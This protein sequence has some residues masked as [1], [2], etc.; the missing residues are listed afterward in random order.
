MLSI[1]I[2]GMEFYDEEK[3]EFVNTEPITMELEH[4]LASLAK[5]ESK[6]RKPFLSSERTV[7]E[8]LDYIKCMTL[9]DVPDDVYYR[10]SKQNLIDIDA[11]IN[12]S[13]TATWFAKDD[14]RPAGRDII[15]AEI[16]YYWMVAQQIPFECQYWHLQR[17]LTLIRVCGEK[18]KP[19]KKMSKNDI[20][21]R[22]NSLNAARRNKLHSRG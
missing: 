17:L 16:I 15:T 20:Y 4:S 13:P 8:T 5:W 2:Q 21:K 18:N 3:N 14:K 12:D 1:V 22:N 10:L 6:H 11:Y 9:N 7:S 19:P